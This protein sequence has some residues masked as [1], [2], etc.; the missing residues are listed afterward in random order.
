MASISLAEVDRATLRTNIASLCLAVSI[1]SAVTPAAADVAVDTDFEGGIGEVLG[2]EPD[3]LVVRIRPRVV[4]GRGFP[5]WWC[6]RVSGLEEQNALTL[7]LN[8][9]ATPF[10]GKRVLSANWS[11]PDYA[12]VSFGGGTWQQTEKGIRK[13]GAVRYTI[14]IPTG[15]KQMKLAWG[16]PFVPSDADSLLKTAQRRLPDAELFELAK[17]RQG[18]PVMGIRFGQR[19]EGGQ[20]VWVQARQHAWEAGGS[21]VGSGFLKWAVSDAPA[22]VALR[23]QTLVHFVPIMDVDSVA[24]G[25]GGKDAV[26]RDHNRDW[27]DSPVYPEVAAAQRRIK[28]LNQEG[29]LDLFIDLHNPGS[30]DR[31]PFFFAPKLEEL[32]GVRQRNY[33]DWLSVTRVVIRDIEPKFRFTSYI[34]SEEVRNRVSSNWVRNHSSSHVV[35]ATLETAWNR[36]G[37]TT[38][39][40]EAVGRDL[41]L[42]I[43]RY[44]R[45]N[46]RREVEPANP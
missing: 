29:V 34:T 32:K 7:E 38:Q 27:D 45:N 9:N 20:G 44:L 26:P 2:I 28:Q 14:K 23:R 22:A 43:A 37:A 6:I 5:C 8:P 35:A 21:W 30:G 10:E 13:D 24:N 11:Q 17:T 3:P 12:A 36:Q 33:T 15:A 31:R 42:S 4:A 25:W 39:Y 16:P 1:A 19:V 41:G 46:P 18:R 40:Y